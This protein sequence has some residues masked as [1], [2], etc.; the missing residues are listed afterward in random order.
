VHGD[1][2]QLLDNFGES[3]V[4]DIAAGDGDFDLP[5]PP[6]C[7]LYSKAGKSVILYDAARAG[8][9]VEN[10]CYVAHTCARRAIVTNNTGII[11]MGNPQNGTVYKSD[12]HVLRRNSALATR[13]VPGCGPNIDEVF[14]AGQ[15]T[16]LAVKLTA[17]D[18]GINYGFI[19]T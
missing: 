10:D 8:T 9:T 11:A 3:K 18:V 1:D 5:L 14:V 17:A 4:L 16:I 15:N 7:K 6:E 12:F 2:H 13:N 19:P